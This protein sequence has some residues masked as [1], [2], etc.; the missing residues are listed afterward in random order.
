MKSIS[1][2]VLLALLSAA[3]Q[4]ATEQE[5]KQAFE[6]AQKKGAVAVY[7]D[8]CGGMDSVYF[9]GASAAKTAVAMSALAT[10]QLRQ[11]ADQDCPT[12]L[13]PGQSQI[14][15]LYPDGTVKAH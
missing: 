11:G 6:K 1:V 14:L 4:A 13:Q 2:V 12:G 8:R 10:V 3:A 5:I 15:D 7:E 9:P